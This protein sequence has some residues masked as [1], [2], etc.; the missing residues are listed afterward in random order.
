VTV[1][2]R[3]G[4]TTNQKRQF[5]G[6]FSDDSGL[7]YLQNRYYNPNQGQFLTQDPAFWSEKQ[8]L[9]NP[10]SFNAYSYAE[11]NPIAFKYAAGKASYYFSN[12]AGFTGNDTWNKGT[13]Y[14]NSDRSLLA[15]NAAYMQALQPASSLSGAAIFTN[16][17]REN[18][19]W[20]FKAKAN[21]IGGER[22]YYFF[23]DQLVDAETFG[24]IHYGYVG[25][26]GVFHK[27]L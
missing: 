17:V 11:N 5:I 27:E 7:S 19:A 6:Q 12:G 21:P 16:L 15:G 26:A 24:N 4:A 25:T 3:S 20:D 9:K 18:G 8:N 14:Q 2:G 10:Q 23:G 13:Y 1:S 22:K